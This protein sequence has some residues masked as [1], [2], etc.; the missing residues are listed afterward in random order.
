MSSLLKIFSVCVFGL[1]IIG[2]SKSEYP[3]SEEEKIN[4]RNNMMRLFIN[5]L[6]NKNIYKAVDRWGCSNKTLRIGKEKLVTC[7]YKMADEE[8]THRMYCPADKR[9]ECRPYE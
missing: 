1:V 7:S 4:V 2:C 8:I 5:P 6:E 3:S 9:A